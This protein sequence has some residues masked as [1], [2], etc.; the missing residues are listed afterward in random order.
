MMSFFSNFAAQQF[1]KCGDMLLIYHAKHYLK[2]TV[3]VPLPKEKTLEIMRHS[4]YLRLNTGQS[5]ELFSLAKDIKLYNNLKKRNKAGC[6]AIKQSLA[7]GQG[8]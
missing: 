6:K 5:W 8:Q 1:S 3:D 7:G 2:L 4:K